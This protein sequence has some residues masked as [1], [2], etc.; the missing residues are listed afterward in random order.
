MAPESPPTEAVTT[1]GLPLEVEA[2]P[3]S[4][5]LVVVPV[6][7]LAELDASPSSLELPVEEDD[8]SEPEPEPEV[9]ELVLVVTANRGR[10]FEA[11]AGAGADA[12]EAEAALAAVTGSSTSILVASS[13]RPFEL[14][15]ASG[16]MTGST[17][18]P[19]RFL[20]VPPRRFV[21]AAAA[22]SDVCGIETV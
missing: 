13:T 12:V 11:D 3:R 5:V 15:D 16:L 22:P 6:V 1:A 4:L 14:L 9:F 20:L 19:G 21:A 17:R 8:C 2:P 18:S 10:L 7:E